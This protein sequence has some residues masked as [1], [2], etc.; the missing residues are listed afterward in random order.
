[1]HFNLFTMSVSLLVLLTG[2]ALAD[3]YTEGASW[4]DIGDDDAITKAFTDLCSH[5]A[6]DYEIGSRVGLH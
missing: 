6:G 2:T 1:M 5:M 4:S 3:C